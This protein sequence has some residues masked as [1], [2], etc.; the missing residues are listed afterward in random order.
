M[1]GL[2]SSSRIAAAVVVTAVLGLGIG[3]AYQRYS[4]THRDLTLAPEL[5]VQTMSSRTLSLQTLTNPVVI[6]NVWASWCEPC[7]EELPSLL[8]MV[9]QMN[10]KVRVLAI[11]Q[12]ED[13]EKMRVFL[14]RFEPLP[15]GF[16][17]VADPDGKIGQKF[18]VQKLPESFIVNRE[19]QIVRKVEGYDDWSTPGALAYLQMLIQD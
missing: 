7:A 19:K 12:D 9:E 11:S 15:E 18:R 2:N 17:V 1:L 6:V 10:G 8:R 5:T 16:D 3:H 14:K 13:Q 4:F